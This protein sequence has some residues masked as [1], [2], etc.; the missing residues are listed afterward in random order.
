[1]IDSTSADFIS[2]PQSEIKWEPM[3]ISDNYYLE[4]QATVD[5]AI[6]AFKLTPLPPQQSFVGEQLGADSVAMLHQSIV[7]RQ[8]KSVA[9]DIADSIERAIMPEFE[10]QAERAMN[11][12]L[13]LE[14]V[15]ESLIQD[16][17]DALALNALGLL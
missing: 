16:F 2:D 15:D 6:N 4:A 10:R 13:N 11:E 1:M 9:T 12:Y 17:S 8:L 3:I 5:K 14:S 7:N